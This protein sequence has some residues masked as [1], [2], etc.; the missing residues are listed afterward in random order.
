[1]NLRTLF[2]QCLANWYW[3][4]ITF[5]AL[6]MIA[7]IYYISTSKKYNVTASIMIRTADE[8]T[9]SPQAEMMSM[10]G[11]SGTKYVDDEIAILTSKDISATIISQLG[12]EWD[13]R[14]RHYLRWDGVYPAP[15]INMDSVRT[16]AAMKVKGADTIWT[17][18]IGDQKYR[19]R[20][21]SIPAL[22]D[23][24][25][26]RIHVTKLKQDSY[27]I[28]LTAVTDVPARECAYINKQIEL[29]NLNSLLEKNSMA[30]EAAYFIDERLRM[31]E[32]ELS[33]SVADA[34]Q[35][36][37]NN[38]MVNPGDEAKVYFSQTTSYQQRLSELQTQQ[39]LINYVENFMHRADSTTLIPT[40]LGIADAALTSLI[41]EYNNLLLRRMRIL[42]TASDSNPVIELINEQISAMRQSI[43]ASIQSARNSL[44]ISIRDLEA[45]SMVARSEMNQS[46]AAESQYASLLRDRDLKEKLYLYLY[47]KREENAIT[48]ASSLMPAKIIDAPKPNSIPATHQ[49]KKIALLILLL[50]LALPVGFIYLKNTL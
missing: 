19:I 37:R 48:L 24:Y 14:V 7:G 17:V 43:Y 3:F 10:M 32:E 8:D 27:I 35:F 6:S 45:R 9:H 31:I 50:T 13:Y 34:E 2:R 44:D 39:N 30:E 4:V 23:T 5:F 18:R 33:Q 22:V 29:Y 12:L 38:N 15:R 41:K 20:R 49:P 21:R 40:N 26:R 16:V 36:R 46:T 1:M 47:Q 28:K 11:Y 42:R 25:S